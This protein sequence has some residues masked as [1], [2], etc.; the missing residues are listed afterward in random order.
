MAGP[1]PTSGF[2]RRLTYQALE[3]LR[4]H[5]LT[6]SILDAVRDSDDLDLN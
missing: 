1:L 3:L 6:R 4:N 2:R 5:S